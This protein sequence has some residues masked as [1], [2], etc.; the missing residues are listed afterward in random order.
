MHS[1]RNFMLFNF[2]IMFLHLLSSTSYLTSASMQLKVFALIL[3]D[4]KSTKL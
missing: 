4:E 3:E 1:C 2:L